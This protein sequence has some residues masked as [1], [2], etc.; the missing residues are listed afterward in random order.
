MEENN[1]FTWQEK[2]FDS[3]QRLKRKLQTSQFHTHNKY[4]TKS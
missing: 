2:V 3:V 4:V 1:V